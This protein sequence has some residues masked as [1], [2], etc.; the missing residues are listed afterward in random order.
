MQPTVCPQPSVCDDVRWAER[1]SLAV[2]AGEIKRVRFRG[3]AIVAVRANPSANR[4]I[5]RYLAGG[6]RINQSTEDD[7]LNT[8]NQNQ[9]QHSS[10]VKSFDESLCEHLPRRLKAI[11]LGSADGVS[12]ERIAEYRAV[13]TSNPGGLPTVETLVEMA[14][15]GKTRRVIHNGSIVWRRPPEGLGDTIDHLLW[16]VGIAQRFTPVVTKLWGKCGCDFR[17]K[18]LNWYLPYSQSVWARRLAVLSL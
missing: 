15:R 18:W 12:P 13:F 16:N 1:R 14:K 4:D 10:E 2:A 11:C 7:K 9:N 8:G 6:M 5:V 3:S 17:R